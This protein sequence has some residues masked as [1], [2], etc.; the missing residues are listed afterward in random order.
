MSQKSSFLF[1]K[2]SPAHNLMYFKFLTF[3]KN[4]ELFPDEYKIM[5]HWIVYLTV[6]S[7]YQI[8]K[9]S[10]TFLDYNKLKILQ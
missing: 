6:L 5:K 3:H 1:L 8:F 7:V 9:V 4:T 10:A 2:M